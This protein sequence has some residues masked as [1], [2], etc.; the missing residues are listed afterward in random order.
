MARHGVEFELKVYNNTTGAFKS[1]KQST[2]QMQERLER[3]Q[4][5]AANSMRPDHIK[6]YNLLIDEQ[7][8][9]IAALQK[10]TET[11]ANKTQSAMSALITKYSSIIKTFSAIAIVNGFKNQGSQ[12][13]MAAAQ[14][15]KYNVTLKTML[16]ST[17]AA[18]DRMQEYFKIAQKTPFELTQVVEAGNRLQALGRYSREN[19]E[20][21]GDLAAASGKPMEQVLTAYSQLATGQRGDAVKMFRDLLITEKEWI[22]GTGK[23]EASTEEML[24]ALPKIMQRKGFLG[25]MASQAETTEGK[26]SNL[27]DAVFGLQS[28]IGKR[29]QPKVNSIVTK[30]TE[31]VSKAEDYVKVPLWQEIAKEKV[32]LNLLVERLIKAN[33]A[34]TDRNGIIAELQRKY[35]EFLKN[36]DAEKATTQQLRDALIETNEEY[37]KRIRKSIYSKRIESLIEQD[38]EIANDIVDY[39]L[40]LEAKKRINEAI[41]KRNKLLNSK[42]GNTGN[43]V[44]DAKGNVMFKSGVTRGG[45]IIYTKIND[46]EVAAQA[47]LYQ[48]EI[49]EAQEYIK[50]ANTEKKNIDKN[51]KKRDAL[52][53]KI[54]YYQRLA[55]L[56]DTTTN[57]SSDD[58]N[59]NS[60][61][62][63]N[64]GNNSGSNNN[65]VTTY[66][67]SGGRGSGRSGSVIINIQ[68]LISGGIT[69][70]TTNLQEGAEQI[71]RIVIQTLMDAT[72]EFSAAG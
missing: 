45:T 70:Q 59:D 67:S 2:S 69:I 13:V 35:P 61:Q 63:D 20:M 27:K 44:S 71:K 34:G 58:S 25:M 57:K 51:Q 28:A 50:D 40:S 6:K 56:N 37:D 68:N 17:S 36:I 62:N 33:E 53:K 31:W 64:S 16:G 30:M 49:D 55:G 23:V 65:A 47:L 11:C 48:Q 54:E 9:R 42:Y 4:T 46:A 29:L 3:L 8:K 41:V 43:V 12:A 24:N 22:K 10:D 39:E 60:S 66:S 21:I 19:L 32:E 26:L 38:T 72:N 1:L 18:R 15:E 7:R 5:A 14:V 52:R